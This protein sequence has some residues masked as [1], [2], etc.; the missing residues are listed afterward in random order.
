MNRV[1]KEIKFI[2]ILNKRN[3]I[4]F[5]SQPPPPG[6]NMITNGLEDIGKMINIQ[7]SS[8][9]QLAC[10]GCRGSFDQ[11]FL[12]TVGKNS[13]ID[14]NKFEIIVSKCI[15]SGIR[16]IELTP[17]VGDPFLDPG[18]ME[19]IIYLNNH[20]EVEMVIVTT[21]LLKYNN[22]MYEQLLALDKLSLNISVYGI[23]KQSYLNET[24]R[25]LFDQ[26]M[27]NFKSLY[28]L[29]QDV[30]VSGFLQ[31]T[32]RT[33]WLLDGDP[34]MPDSDMYFLI[35][36]Y[37]R[38]NRVSVD[39]SEVFNINRA[40]AVKRSDLSFIRDSKP[41]RKGLCPH[42]PGLG[43]GILPNGD[44]L[45]CPFNDIYRKGVIGNIF[46]NTL[47]EIY[48]DTPFQKLIEEHKSDTYTGI[49]E[50]CNETW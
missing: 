41:V 16:C 21:N 26:F 20:P 39:C 42:G 38:Q 9:C 2:R 11:G 14:Q 24:G 32:N 17:A 12:N 49:C 50:K 19:K 29:I 18:I 45:F 6:F 40:G 37:N 3:K 8:V 7:T 4:V 34:Q 25:D 15:Q 30:N 23:D 48:N 44:V 35:N 5:E 36:L 28:E 33:S 47:T 1:D 22:D 31:L 27:T 46:K 10:K 43:G 13:F